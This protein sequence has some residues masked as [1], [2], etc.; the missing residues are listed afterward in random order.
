MVIR[1]AQT[2]YTRPAPSAIMGAR[3]IGPDGDRLREAL[4]ANRP[5][6]GARSEKGRV[7]PAST[8]DSVRRE[9]SQ[10]PA[11]TRLPPPVNEWSLRDPVVHPLADHFFGE[12]GPA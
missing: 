7:N 11:T 9:T 8:G 5:D 10:P 3:V 1:F 12:R 6:T 4:A 2:T